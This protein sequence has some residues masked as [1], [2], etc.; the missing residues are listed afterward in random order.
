[1]TGNVLSDVATSGSMEE[2]S[3]KKLLSKLL[4]QALLGQVALFV[5]IF[6]PGTFVYWQAWAF[7]AV[8]G[9]VAIYFSVYF[10]CT[11]PELLAR[12]LLRK[13]KFGAQKAIILLL[14][15]VSIAAYV[16]SA[17]DHRFG[18]SQTYLIA[19]PWWLTVLSLIGYAISY[20][21]FIPVFDANRFAASVIQVETGQVV[22]D[23]GPYRRVRHPMYAVALVVWFWIPLSLGSFVALPI[24]LLLLP[25][26]MLR[27]LHEEKV[28]RRELPGYAEYCQRTRY[29]L[30]PNVW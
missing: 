14:K 12:R 13:E 18:W 1:M 22:I 9:A 3:R 11:N 16:L 7:M 23:T 8:N 17:L 25:V 27:L 6:V 4:F 5:F 30:I 20:L 28:L 19:V 2:A 24:A 21:R 29:R 26:L 10:Y 15:Y